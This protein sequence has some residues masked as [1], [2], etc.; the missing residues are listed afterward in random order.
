MPHSTAK[1]PAIGRSQWLA[2]GL[3]VLLA[4]GL[5]AGNAQAEEIQRTITITGQ[6]QVSVKPD[7]AIVE[8]GV[9]TQAKTAAEALTANTQA[10]QAVFATLKEVGIEDKDMRT[11]QF[12]VNA[13]HTRPERGEARRITGYQVSN[14]VSVTIRD[15]DRVGEVLDRVVSNGSN[16]L[17]GIRFQVENPGPL[18]D[19]ARE[20]AVKD[21][22]RKAKIY[23]AAAGVALGPVLTINEHGG[24]GRPQP[25]FAR[26]MAMEA[27]ADVPIAAGEQTLSTSVTLVIGLE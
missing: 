5:F 6:G 15:L 25:M 27:A 11:S 16:E 9:V 14:L 10:M 18:M 13:I 26:S 21:A 3:G 8:S 20:D 4:L 2:M 7:I 19:G 23:V 22:L 17:R 1:T 12:S 24:G